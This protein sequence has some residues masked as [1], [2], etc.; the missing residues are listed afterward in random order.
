MI[1]H[2]DLIK[3]LSP[4][5][6][7]VLNK[8]DDIFNIFINKYDNWIYLSTINKAKA[9][10]FQQ[11]NEFFRCH[12][13]DG[14]NS[15]DI[16]MAHPNVFEKI[17]CWML[18]VEIFDNP[19]YNNSFYMRNLSGRYESAIM[20][21]REE[22]LSDTKQISDDNVREEVILRLNEFIV[23]YHNMNCWNSIG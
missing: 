2:K 14:N 6:I 7:G 22:I 4:P 3:L 5:I 15:I 12:C 21:V 20:Q 23:E 8:D 17:R 11:N 10:K 18:A 9:F 19:K 13:Y 16:V 1:D